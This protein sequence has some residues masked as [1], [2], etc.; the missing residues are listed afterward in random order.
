MTE[1]SST[2]NSCRWKEV[3]GLGLTLV[4]RVVP[5]VLWPQPWGAAPLVQEEASKSGWF[6]S[7]AGA[8]PS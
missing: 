1:A 2:S 4:V 6:Q 8:V 3:S 5:R 7:A